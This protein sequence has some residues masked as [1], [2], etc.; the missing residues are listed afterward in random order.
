M[1]NGAGA[2]WGIMPARAWHTFTDRSYLLLIVLLL[3]CHHGSL[4]SCAAVRE[5]VAQEIPA[6]NGGAR[7]SR[8]RSY[9][10]SARRYRPMATRTPTAS[11]RNARSPHPP[12]S[13]I[14][15]RPK[16]L[17]NCSV[18]SPC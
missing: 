2:P 3:L 15:P 10:L 14:V 6:R 8:S 7:V 11:T 9:G 17:C 5:V 18:C 13:L 16:N 1:S 12:D 4:H